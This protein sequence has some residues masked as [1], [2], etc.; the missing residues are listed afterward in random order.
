MRQSEAFCTS[1]GVRL[2]GKKGWERNTV[3]CNESVFY[4]CCNTK[5][6]LERQDIS[7]NNGMAESHLLLHPTSLTIVFCQRRLFKCKQFSGKYCVKSSGVFLPSEL[8]LKQAWGVM[9]LSS[10]CAT[11]LPL[12]TLLLMKP[13]ET[14][15]WLHCEGVGAQKLK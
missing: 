10:G 9:A 3:V 1:A 6:R 2:E 11:L 15:Q 13:E 14:T 7:S 4:F 5:S 12:R 8:P